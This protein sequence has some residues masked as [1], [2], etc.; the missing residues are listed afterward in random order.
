MAGRPFSS[1]R[2]KPA[3]DRFRL[4]SPSGESGLERRSAGCWRGRALA[5]EPHDVDVG[6]LEAEE[7]VHFGGERPRRASRFANR[8][9]HVEAALD[10]GK[11]RPRLLVLG[12]DDD[13]LVDLIEGV[14]HQT[15]VVLIEEG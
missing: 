2:L 12:Y 6:H 14:E 4:M 15:E 9:A 1:L 8:Q 7:T 13:V 3:R 5:Q 11:E 10:G